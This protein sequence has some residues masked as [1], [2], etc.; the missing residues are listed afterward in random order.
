MKTYTLKSD[1]VL[2][3]YDYLWRLSS[4]R[5]A[6]EY[7]RRNPEFRRDAATRG[8]EDISE[9]T[10]PC[11][12]IRLLRARVPQTLA[13]RWGLMI[14]PDPDK[15]GFDAD[16]FWSHPVHPDQVEVHCSPRS[17]G[18]DLRDL[19]SHGPALQ[20]HASDRPAGTGGLSSAGKWLCCAGA[21]HGPLS[22]RHGEDTHEAH[23]F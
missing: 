15:N 7:L 19:G 22:S 11:A 13:E 4:D 20:D 2:T 16:V 1:G 17:E 23:D 3:R 21:L 6:W 8:D 9:M 12:P 18:E 14:M 5:W 10:A